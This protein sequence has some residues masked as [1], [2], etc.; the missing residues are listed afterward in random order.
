MSLRP[1]SEVY[2]RHPAHRIIDAQP[3]GPYAAWGC[4][5]ALEFDQDSTSIP[6]WGTTAIFNLAEDGM[7]EPVY[8]TK[9]DHA[10]AFTVK[11]LSGKGM[12]LRAWPSGATEAV[13]LQEDQVDVIGS[14][15]AYSYVNT[16]SQS[17]LLREVAIPAFAPGDDLELNQSLL[18]PDRDRQNRAAA[19]DYTYY[20]TND[21]QLKS[22]I[23]PSKFYALLGQAAAGLLKS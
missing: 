6:H 2:K 14:G 16:G 1:V 10:A 7:T 21:G 17:L 3:E 15:Q 13:S 9:S 18:R 23:L 4:T 5:L 8:I 20:E 12:L 22:I 11:V 19:V